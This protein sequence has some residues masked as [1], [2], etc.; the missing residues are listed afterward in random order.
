[1]S[2]KKF[3]ISLGRFFR[4]L[5]ENNV[6]SLTNIILILVVVKLMMT[7]DTS[8]ENIGVIL[9]GLMNYVH[10][11]QTVAKKPQ[12]EDV[13]TEVKKKVS[14]FDAE[15]REMKDKL[16]QVSVALSIRSPKKRF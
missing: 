10:K 13:N 3:F 16:G 1:M 6:L 2:F 14:E 9:L 7:P 5:D 15:L 11:R 12:V 8:L 4:L